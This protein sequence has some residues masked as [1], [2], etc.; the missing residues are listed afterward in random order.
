[1]PTPTLYG[2]RTIAEKSLVA[3]FTDNATSLPGVAL[4]AGQTDEIRSVP[5]IICHA[6]SAVAH[7]DFGA[8]WSGNFEITAKIYVYSSA[9]DST[10]EQ[11]RARVEAVQGI[12]QDPTALK[13]MWTQ[14]TLYATWMNSDEEGVADRRY[15]NVLSY[16]LVAVYPPAP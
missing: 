3:L 10:L 11:H 14:G 7:R 13:S 4:H 1:M 6:E 12:M 8:L 15:G 2:I 9:D 5:I 16:T